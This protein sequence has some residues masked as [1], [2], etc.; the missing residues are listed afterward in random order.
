M[1]AIRRRSLL[2]GTA[3]AAGLLAAPA[4]LRAQEVKE[5]SFFYP[6]TVSAPMASIIEEYCAQ[7]AKETGVTV[8][9]TYA[10]TYVDTL[11]KAVTAIRG[12]NGPQFSVMLTA[13]I[14][15]LQAL[16][17]I[18]P[19]EDIGLD[20]AGEDWVASFWPAFMFNTRIAGKTWSVPF[21][22]ST[23]VLF[24]NKA[25]F[26]KAGLDPDHYPADW[27]SQALAAQKLT[28]RGASP[29][30]WGI[31]FPADITNGHWTFGALCGGNGF[32]LM[33]AEGTKTYFDDPKA[34]EALEY[35]VSLSK[36]YHATPPG[37]SY[38]STLVPNFLR[39]ST[40]IICSS[41]GNLATIT[42]SA[43]F[44]FDVALPAGNPNPGTVVGGG[45]IYIFK[46]ASPAQRQAA[47]RFA[48]WLTTP[49]RAAD[50]SIRTGYV[51]VTEPA[52]SAPNMQA[53]IAKHPVA[54]R[55]KSF[56]PVAHGELST[57]QDA[58]ISTLLENHIAAALSGSATPEAALKAAQTEADAIL[59]PYQHA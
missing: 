38:W 32:D 57:Y 21:Q 13:A 35:W 20:K 6:V 59:R 34:I 51:C 39:G 55:P 46:H 2:A 28:D 36:T 18:V 17:V 56:L 44:P 27:K 53:Y 25:A 37:V 12:G 26:T 42:K 33:N 24:Y 43:T 4:I 11:S 10:G 54:G 49:E 30:T 40:S 23:M 47:L 16:D 3:G 19:L 9:A 14:H 1:P 31:Q 8:R 48:Q 7:Y 22:R 29:A 45:N 52:F 41:S 50:W 5:L 58:R 15:T